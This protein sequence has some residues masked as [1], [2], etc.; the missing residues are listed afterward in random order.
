VA[1]VRRQLGT[2][3]VGHAG[4]LDPFATGLLVVLVGKSTRLARFVEGMSKR[5]RTVVRF[6]TATDTDDLTGRVISESRPEQWPDRATMEAHV[7]ALIG[8]HAQRPPAFSAKHVAGTRSHVLARRGEAVELAEVDVQVHSIDTLDWTAPDLTLDAQVSR[9]TYIRALA[10]D[11]GADIGIPAHCAELRRTAIGAFDVNDAIAP[12]AVTVDRLMSPASLV[13]QLPNDVLD[14]TGV[15]EIGFG[16][17]VE[18]QSPAD[19][20]GALLGPDGRLLAVAEGR[21]GWWYPVVVLEPA[22]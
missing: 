9:G 3:A 21:A 12:D 20:T 6:G 8:S 2:R 17:R 1:V 7:A 22:S 4:T 14:E 11:L 5:Y 10:R 13:Q 18:Q 19:T 16:R 15:T